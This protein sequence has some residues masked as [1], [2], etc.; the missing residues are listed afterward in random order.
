MGCPVEVAPIIGRP[1]SK[2]VSII[3]GAIGF[4]AVPGLIEYR[5]EIHELCK[6]CAVKLV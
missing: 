1:I 4:I 2:A 5:L 6:K 3:S